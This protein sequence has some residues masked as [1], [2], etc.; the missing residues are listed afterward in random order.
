MK[1]RLEAGTIM[2]ALKEN[3]ESLR[4]LGVR[5]IG[6]FGSFSRKEQRNGSDIDFWWFQQTF[7]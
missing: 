6:L 4:E 7:F 3:R 1:N 2:R 5:K